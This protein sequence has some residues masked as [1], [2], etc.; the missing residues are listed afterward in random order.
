MK[1]KKKVLTTG[2]GM[3]VDNDLNSLTAGLKGPLLVQDIHLH[4]KAG[5][6]RPRADPGTRG[7]R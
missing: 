2:F 1:N 4:R 7:P 6:L 5:T 3:P